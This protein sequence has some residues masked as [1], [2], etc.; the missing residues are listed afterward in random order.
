MGTGGNVSA[1]F[2]P[3][4]SLEPGVGFLEEFGGNESLVDSIPLNIVP[5]DLSRI[6]GILKN[7]GDIPFLKSIPSFSM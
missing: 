1:F 6:E 4:G 7:V 5:D 3:V 2:G